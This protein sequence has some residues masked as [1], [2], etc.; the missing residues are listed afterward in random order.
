MPV[1]AGDP[2]RYRLYAMCNP[3]GDQAG[4]SALHIVSGCLIVKLES[5]GAV[6]APQPDASAV[7]RISPLVL[8][9]D[10]ILILGLPLSTMR[11]GKRRGTAYL[12][13]LSCYHYA[14]ASVL[15]DIRL[16]TVRVLPTEG[17]LI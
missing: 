8:P 13:R 12:A 9:L 6:T 7:R 15:V 16:S 10:P 2:R 5:S 1:V 17:A 4:E 14:G 3:S 11:K